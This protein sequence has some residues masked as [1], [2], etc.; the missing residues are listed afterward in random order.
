MKDDFSFS[1]CGNGVCYIFK[2]VLKVLLK[3]RKFIEEITVKV[4][5]KNECWFQHLSKYSSSSICI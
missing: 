3:K 2:R 4:S 5:G 1:F